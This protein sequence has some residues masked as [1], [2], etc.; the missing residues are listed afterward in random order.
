[1]LKKIFF[2][3]AFVLAI[4]GCDSASAAIYP[5]MSGTVVD[6]VTGKPVQGASVLV[7][8]TKNVLRP[9]I[10]AG[11]ELI[12]ARLVETGK[13]GHYHIDGIMKLLG[14]FEFK[15]D[16][17]L[18]VYQP[19]YK[20]HVEQEYRGDS[21]EITKS[22]NPVALERV[23][24]DFDHGKHYRDIED[25]LRGVDDYSHMSPDGSVTWSSIKNSAVKGHPEKQELLRRAYW[26][27][28]R[29]RRKYER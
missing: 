12:E 5:A 4:F 21:K 2:Y 8:W 11:S 1:M 17:I 27:E 24:A 22:E 19:G 13:N 29:S 26:E 10:E 7:Y 20:V 14:P 6:V 9:P 15:G 3:M 23:P 18:V 25:A 16:T 28:E